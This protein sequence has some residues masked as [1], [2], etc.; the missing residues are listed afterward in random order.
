[1]TDRQAIDTLIPD[2]QIHINARKLPEDVRADLV[3]VSVLED[4]NAAGTFT[5]TLLCW[6]S[7]TMQVKWIDD[8][9]FQA[10]GDVEIKMG[11]RDNLRTLF[12]GEITGLEPEFPEDTP[13]T[14]TIRGYDR[15][16][17][18]MRIKKTRTYM[19]M[20][21]S[22]I[23]AQVAG[24]W[25]LAPKTEDSQVT[26]PYVLQ[27]NQTD[28]EFLQSRAQRIGYEMVVSDKSLFFRPRPS[29]GTPSV[30]L[31]RE[32]ELIDFTVRLS[33][34]GQVEEVFVRGWNPSGKEEYVAHSV[35]GSEQLMGGSASGST[36]VQQAFGNTGRT[37]VDLPVHSQ[38]EADQ[39][40]D[41]QL[42][43]T[44]MT[45]IE[46]YGICIGIADLRAGNS[47]KIQ[48]IGQRFSGIYY[49]TSSEHKYD[50][51]SGYRTAITVRRNST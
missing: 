46:G 41:G 4:V 49:V 9:I 30:T 20:R 16:H 15:R 36:A 28:F 22:E 34:V 14:L 38:A 43:E 3:S 23:A 42:K 27:H 10:G 25:G 26:Y 35:A 31:R 48:G 6:D 2:L 17:R 39:L 18:L 12:K 19:N 40:A 44:A 5:F 45:Y 24:D 51:R 11:Y 33:T 50:P 47:V 32:V 37:T 1:M 13:P 29:M 7:I 21:D 8:D